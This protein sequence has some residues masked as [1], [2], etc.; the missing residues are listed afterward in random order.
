MTDTWIITA[1]GFGL[2]LLGVLLL[3]VAAILVAVSR[4]RNSKM[5]TAGVIIIGPVPIVF[6][7]DKKTVK[8]LLILSTALTLSL[9]AALLIYNFL[10]R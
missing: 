7:S 5:K 1:A 6:G 10:F 3:V 9:V 2:V 4:T 8:T